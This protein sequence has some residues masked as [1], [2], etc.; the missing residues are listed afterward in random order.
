MQYG[1][2]YDRRAI[3]DKIKYTPEHQNELLNKHLNQDRT[4]KR[5]HRKT[6]GKISFSSLSKQVSK[7]WK[8]LSEE[9]K[10]FYKELSA[11]DWVRYKR[12]V[13]ELDERAW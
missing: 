4:K 8:E 13:A 1:I 6:H 10:D 5:R 11:K 7:H 12:E 9:I 3:N 2:N